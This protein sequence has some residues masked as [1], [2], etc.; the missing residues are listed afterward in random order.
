MMTVSNNLLALNATNQ[1]KT[2]VNTKVKSMEKLSSGYR[3]N[4]AADDAA[5]LS[6]SE[7]MR[8]M[9]RGLDQGT[10]NVQDGVSWVQTGDGALDDAHAIMHRMTELT[11]QSL[12]DT[13]T[14]EDR[15][16][17]HTSELHSQR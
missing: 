5:G 16:E 14:D 11:I 2:N 8:S 4:K 15:S 9:I 13:N 7:K 1:L 10:K 17:E 12:N 6:I 3:I